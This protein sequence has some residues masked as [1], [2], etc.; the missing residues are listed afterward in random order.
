MCTCITY[1][2]GDFYFGRNLDL[3]YHFGEKVVITPRNYRL[4]FK[5]SPELESHYA[6]VGMASV[7][8][9]YPLYA[10]AVNE[11][12]LCMAGLNFPGNAC[13]YQEDPEKKN[14][15]PYELIPWILGQCEDVCQARKMLEEINLLKLPF[16]EYLPLAP[17]HW[18]IADR[19]ACI[20][21]E[22]VKDGIHVYE[23]PYGVLT[24]NP[25]FPYYQNHMSYY[26]N[27]TRNFPDNQFAEKLELP[28]Y[29][30]GLGAVGLPGDFSPV[31]R[32]VKAVFLKWNA[33]A[34]PEENSNIAEFFHILDGVAMVRGSVLTAE[35]RADLTIY[36][37][38][39]NT[40]LGIYYYKTYE[41]NQ[42][43][44]VSL[45]KENLE[46]EQLK[47]FELFDKQNIQ[48]RN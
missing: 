40:D 42:I 6:M 3:E 17:L 23:N 22:S 16:S 37:C 32:F 11:K 29:G 26:R 41:N 45:Q 8:E 39:V 30:Q 44:A 14:I 47:C 7:E 28:V 5:K 18:M 27:L 20:I 24:N 1:E 12:G 48:W 43:Q 19:K 38:C 33:K 2:N 9:G 31:S 35:E 15:T 46:S 4:H 36:S 21:L 25:P 13:Y 10:E 34:E